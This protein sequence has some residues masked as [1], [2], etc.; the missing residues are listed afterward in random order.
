MRVATDKENTT[1][2]IM[3]LTN[4]LVNLSQEEMLDFIHQQLLKL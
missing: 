4:N 3:P 1:K 2:S